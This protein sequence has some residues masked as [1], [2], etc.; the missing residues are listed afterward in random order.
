MKDLQLIKNTTDSRELAT[1]VG[2]KHSDLLR[3][4]RSMEGAWAKVN[5]RTFSLVEY[6]DS[7]GEK[8]PSYNLNRE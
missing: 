5:G 4:I 6:M 2:K 3:S 7:K 8:R 1:F